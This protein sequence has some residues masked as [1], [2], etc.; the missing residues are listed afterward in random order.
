MPRLAYRC[1]DSGLEVY[2]VAL[3]NVSELKEILTNGILCI[4]TM[5]PIGSMNSRETS[6]KSMKE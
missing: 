3:I 4:E 1:Q 5:S 2:A 6:Q